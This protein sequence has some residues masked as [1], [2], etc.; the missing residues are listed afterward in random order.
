MLYN[1]MFQEGDPESM[2]LLQVL[3]EHEPVKERKQLFDEKYLDIL[4]VFDMDPQDPQFLPDKLIRMAEFFLES[5]DTGK[6][7]INYPMVEAFYHMSSIPDPNYNDR[8]ATYAELIARDYKAR[9]NHENR[10]HDYT[11]FAVTKDECNIVIRQNI[12]KA[13]KLVGHIVSKEQPTPS[14]A[15]ILNTQLK[16]LMQQKIVSVLSTCTF[17]IADYNPRLLS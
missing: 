8:Y 2:D 15:D 12:E 5:T 11:K 4:L 9:V 1:T 16:L 3:K 7:Y 6:L 10:N 13:E 17:F 14:Q